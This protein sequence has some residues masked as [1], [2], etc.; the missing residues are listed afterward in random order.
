MVFFQSEYSESQN[1][2]YT[3]TVSYTRTQTRYYVYLPTMV[4]TQVISYIYLPFLAPKPAEPSQEDIL[5]TS[6]ISGAITFVLSILIIFTIK[7]YQE[8][9]PDSEVQEQFEERSSDSIIEHI[10]ALEHPEENRIPRLK[11]Y[12][13]N[14]QSEV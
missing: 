4:R 2:S 8:P 11:I 6:V 7:R 1:E 14:E 10:R 12:N 3:L 5:L 13:L 9:H